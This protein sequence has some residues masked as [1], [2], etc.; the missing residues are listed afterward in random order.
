MSADADAT[1]LE[2]CR[3]C[4]QTPTKCALARGNATAEG[5]QQKILT[6]VDE[7]K[8]RPVVMGPFIVDHDF[9]SR[10]IRPA[11]Y[12]P[13]HW[14]FFAAW[15][16]ALFTGDM[17]AASA[18]FLVLVARF[19]AIQTGAGVGDDSA[20]GIQC[21]DKIPRVDSLDKFLPVVDDFTETSRSIGQNNLYVA[22]ACAQW[23][24]E[25]KE[26]Y[27]GDFNVKT[28]NPLFIFSNSY[29]PATPLRSAQNVSAGF[30]GSVLLQSEGFGVSLT[31]FFSPPVEALSNKEFY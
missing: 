4:L 16:D 1:L 23:K 24:I 12:N 8:F 14:P 11:L 25:A 20:V 18:H 22:M 28:K 31:W 30:E 7:A 15:L 13:A 2:F 19:P 6:F 21:I 29:D 5:L 9:M 27:K 26:T 10:N 3:A 17:I